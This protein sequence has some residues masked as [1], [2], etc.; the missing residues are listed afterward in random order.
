MN[1]VRRAVVWLKAQA[2]R[3][4]GG[5]TSAWS[6]GLQLGGLNRGRID[7]AALVGDGRGNA[8]VVAVIRWVQRTF[9][10][11]TPIV[12][13]RLREGDEEAR[14]DHDLVALLNR[15]NEFYSGVHLWSATLADWLTSGNAYWYK[16]RN[17]AGRVVELWWVPSSLIEPRWPDDGSVF[18]SHYDYNPD[19]RFQ[20]LAVDDVVHFRDGIDPDNIRK[21]L[22]PLLSLARELFTDDE[23]AAFSA[24][25]LRNLGVPGVIISPDE[26]VVMSQDDAERIKAEFSHRYSGEGRG[27]AM[28]MSAKTQTTVLSFSPQQMNL[29]DIRRV[30]E[31][32]VTAIYGVP[33]MVLGLGAGLDRSTYSNYEQA[34][35]AA[36]ESMIFPMQRLFLAELNT[37]LMDDFEDVRKFRVAFDNSQ[38]RV[39]AEDTDA[40][41]TR[42]S[43]AQYLTVNEKRTQVGLPPFG[44]EGD[45]L[46][47]PLTLTPMRPQALGGAPTPPSTRGIIHA[48]PERKAEPRPEAIGGHLN[49]TR[50]RLVRQ[51]QPEGERFFAAQR[52]RVLARLGGTKADNIPPVDDL[53]P[54]I[55]ET[56]RTRLWL[57]VIYRDVL[58]IVSGIVAEGFSAD[59]SFTD[60]LVREYLD[61]CGQ[62]IQG[63]SATTRRDVQNA[64]LAGIDAGEGVYAMRQRIEQLPAF[65]AYRAEM[66]VR[67]E[68]ARS[69]NQASLVSYRQSGLVVGVRMIDGTLPTSCAECTARNGSILSLSDAQAANDLG[70]IVREGESEG[71]L[72]HPHCTLVLVPLIDTAQMRP[73]A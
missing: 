18:I 47:L 3:F 2:L 69:M 49:A 65:N 33:A 36:Y 30:P 44:P 52:R 8:I 72:A 14:P 37:Q 51:Y 13:E 70:S 21:G 73:A 7:Y 27:Q 39:L 25:L 58:E 15:P 5:A 28:V 23:A 64:L 35:E 71:L 53:F 41:Y 43:N 61:V 45:V 32:R 66:V 6:W 46:L 48:L 60:E 4:A 40:L 9:P 1:P 29:K 11:A 56:E 31:E 34:R 55:V 42:V 63:I 59:I 26:N 22:S 16:A 57:E 54:T 68:L 50:A 12:Y 20:Q 10:E 38:I 24:S 17:G 19:G 67:T 62:L